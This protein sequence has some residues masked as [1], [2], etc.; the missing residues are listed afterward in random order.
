MA[1]ALA[2]ADVLV[3]AVAVAFFAV[4]VL[5]A[6]LAAVFFVA[7]LAVGMDVL[8]VALFVGLARVPYPHIGEVCRVVTTRHT[9]V[10]SWSP[11]GHLRAR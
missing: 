10:S 1:G 2:L 6:L 11:R 5:A 4:A 8:P 9:R 7:R 3:A